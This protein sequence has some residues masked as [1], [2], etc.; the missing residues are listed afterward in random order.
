MKSLTKTQQE[1]VNSIVKEFETFNAPINDADPNDLLAFINN[2]IN[3]KQR[4]IDEIKITNEAYDR[5]NESQVIEYIDQMNSILNSFGYYCELYYAKEESNGRGYK[6]Y[7]QV[8]IT[9]SGHKNDRYFDE[10]S[11]IFFFSNAVLK[12][13]TWHLANASLKIYKKYRGDEIIESLDGLLKYV[14][15]MIIVKRK[16]LI[17]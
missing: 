15:E 17:K 8:R 14:A 9:W 6:E 13:N 10:H 4:F 1:I 7:F 3:E 12:E 16:S 5:A 11:E 2:A